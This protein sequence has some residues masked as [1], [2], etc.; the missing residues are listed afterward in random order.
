[1]P[2]L[3]ILDTTLR[4]GSDAP[5]FAPDAERRLAIARSL[6]A[7]QI[8]VI[9][10]ASSDAPDV[11]AAQALCAAVGNAEACV[12]GPATSDVV[13]DA[14]VRLDGAQ[15]PRIHLY[16]DVADRDALA[17]TLEALFA[18]RT[19]V[20]Q[21]EFSPLHAFGRPLD[22]VAEL[23]VSAVDSGA[24]V[25]NLSDSSG[26]ATTESVRALVERVVERVGRGGTTSF[27]G[28]NDGGR[29]VANAL[30]AC[31]AGAR[32][33][34]VCV[35]GVG[36][37]GGNTSLEDLL[38]EIDRLGSAAVASPLTDRDA[39]PALTGLVAGART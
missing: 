38:A 28:H 15:R 26:S 9:E 32:Q 30:A 31:A 6:A 10:L 33:I 39:L 35:S 20:E 36:P 19:N 29:A 5:G 16:A 27:H 22:E 3:R 13:A 37:R 18:A 8:D 23:A 4:D 24:T 14:L 34:H 1:M 12:I 17:P 21:V 7:A 11:D 25:V 2:A